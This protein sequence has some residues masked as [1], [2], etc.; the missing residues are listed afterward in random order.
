MSKFKPRFS[1]IE[2]QRIENVINLLTKQ[3]EQSGCIE[4]GGNPFDLQIDF[5]SHAVQS[6]NCV[7]KTN[8]V[9]FEEA[10]DEK[11]S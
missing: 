5:C 3:L 7:L 8:L 2:E 9:K 10:S 1:V 6:L 4:S 11:Q